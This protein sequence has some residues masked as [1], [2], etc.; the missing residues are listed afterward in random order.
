MWGSPQARR[1]SGPRPCFPGLSF[2]PPCFPRPRFPGRELRGWAHGRRSVTFA[3]S[4]MREGLEETT[5]EAPSPQT[6]DEM[7]MKMA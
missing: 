1:W 5:T 3:A 4:G 6:G 2:P 7:P